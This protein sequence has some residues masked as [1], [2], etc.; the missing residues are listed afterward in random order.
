MLCVGVPARNEAGRYLAECLSAAARVA[1][2]V[3]VLDDASTDQTAEVAASYTPLVYTA[4]RPLFARDE[5]LLRRLLWDLCL[6]TGADW[7][8]M[9]DADELLE[10]DPAALAQALADPGAQAL[11]LRLYDLWDG[12]GQYRD[13]E[14]WSAHTRH[15]TLAVRSDARP[16]P[17]WPDR[18]LHCGRFPLGVRRPSL[19]LECARVL[20]LGWLAPEDRVRKA[21]RYASMDPRGEWGWPAQ[22]ASIAD[23]SPRLAPLPPLPRKEAVPA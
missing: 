18:P 20:H 1:D 15:H 3:V 9:L 4:P 13:D 8:M 22:Y 7:I 12:R 17:V 5:R 19:D 14:W 10:C 23:P 2:T 6:G 21:R 16:D 11:G